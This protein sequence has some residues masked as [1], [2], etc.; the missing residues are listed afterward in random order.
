MIYYLNRQMI[1][2][3]KHSYFNQLG[4]IK[5]Y[6]GKYAESVRFYEKSIQ[7]NQKILSPPHSDLA[8]SYVSLG[9]LCNKM[10]EYSKTFSYYEKDLDV[11][12]KNF[13]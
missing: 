2:M 7:I 10:D 5:D 11:D 8:T 6:Q 13:L 4:W 9:L 12:K 1:D 3:K